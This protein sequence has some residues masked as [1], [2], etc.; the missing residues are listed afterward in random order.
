MPSG[1]VGHQGIPPFGA[2]TLSNPFPLKHKMRYTL[3]AQM[4]AHCKASL[5]GTNDQRID[6]FNEHVLVRS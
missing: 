5:S 4:L 1:A 6:R 3:F 2:P